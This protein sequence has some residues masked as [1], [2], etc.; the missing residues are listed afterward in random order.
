VPVPFDPSDWAP[1]PV[2]RP[3]IGV[4]SPLVSGS[5]FGAILAGINRRAAAHGR[6][7]LAIQTLDAVS[8]YEGAPTYE[9]RLAWDHVDRFITIINAVTEEY[10]QGLLDA[11]KSLVMIS[12]EDVDVD[13]PKVV[14]DNV[15]GVRASV[16]HLVAHGHRRIAFAGSLSQRD[17]R[18]RYEAYQE[19]LREAG[20]E[21]EPELLYPARE[22]TELGG[23][24]AAEMM[25]AAGMPASAVVTATDYNA[26]GLMATLRQAGVRLPEDLAVIGFDDVEASS[27]QDPALSTVTQR[28]DRMGEMA[29]DLVCGPEIGRSRHCAPTSLV[30]R[31]SCGCGPAVA[32]APA[33]V[34]GGERD[35]FPAIV[36]GPIEAGERFRS[37]LTTALGS[38]T[39][40]DGSDA[41]SG[42]V[43]EH[44]GELLRRYQQPVDDDLGP[45]I[46]R[47]LVA[48]YRLDPRQRTVVALAAATQGLRNELAAAGVPS[49]HLDRCQLEATVCLSTV[50][51]EEQARLTTRLGLSLRTEYAVTFDLLRSHE[52]DARSLT[53]LAR[54]QARSGCFGVW[55]PGL[56]ELL[57]TNVYQRRGDA[58]DGARLSEVLPSLGPETA[59]QREEHYAEAA[60][61]PGEVLDS[62]QAD[63]DTVTYLLPV[64]TPSTNW[65]VLAVVGPVEQAATTGHDLFY[66][67]AGMLGITLD[68]EALVESLREQREGLAD[69]YRRERELVETLRHSEERYA[70]AAR[71]ASDGLWDW[72]LGRNTVYYSPRWKALLGYSDETVGTS[73][74]EWISR[75]H[76][77]DRPGLVEAIDRGLRGEAESFELEH[78][79]LGSDGRHRWTLCRAL[80]VPGGGKPATRLVGSLSDITPRRE[81]EDRLLQRAL[82]DS[83]TGLPN[84][85]LFLDRLER[86]LS[87][88]EVNGQSCALFFMD[89]DNFKTVNDSLGHAAGDELLTTVGKR[90][91]EVL[92]PEDTVARLG[93][94]EFVVLAENVSATVAAEIAERLRHAI[95]QPIVLAE[96]TL[97]VSCS[98]GIALSADHGPDMLLQEADTALYQAKEEGRNRAATYN[99]SMRMKAQRRLDVESILREALE[100]G[101]L[102]V[103][104]QPIVELPS[105]AVVGNE[106][107]VRIRMDD[108]SLLSPDQFIPVAESTGLILPLG[109]AVLNQACA[110]QARW[111]QASN[112]P[113]HV[114][115][116]LSPC[117]L[118]DPSLV[119]Q[120]AEALALSG[121][122]ASQLY[123]ELTETALLD[124]SPEVLQAVNDLKAMGVTLAI[125]DFGTGWAS[126]AYLR[127]FPIDLLKIDRSFVSGILDNDQD[128]EVV[129]AVISLGH[130]L[131][132]K[133]VAEGVETDEQGRRLSEMG[134]DLAQG[135]F[136]GR[137]QL[138]EAPGH[139]PQHS[140]QVPGY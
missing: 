104:Y 26:H 79:I 95:N 46:R 96:R 59:F 41:L 20:I 21:P 69:A 77:D 3:C 14:P 30:L 43:A 101:H 27:H 91:R 68:R 110:Q 87:R 83:L 25:L 100:E 63:D 65:G 55:T 97:A 47:T 9:Q 137:P 99:K 70:L 19:A 105:G 107:L 74:D 29:V 62:V 120:V 8:G 73:P 22:T 84:R 115:V 119:G 52:R 61:P 2:R 57:V 40:D 42:L 11:G 33:L 53:W 114:A 121:L 39:P 92:R 78:R 135:Y 125:D 112:P 75:V 44:A 109:A 38:G 81:L 72:D 71:A 49:D 4:L 106:A 58:P 90:L 132:L 18:E 13:C 56:A 130:A 23:R 37:A 102:V 17:M 6:R 50:G 12:P 1:H 133:V 66:Q 32:A 16:R 108:G 111:A 48:L 126:L 5:Y 51:A 131:A 82:Y 113:G 64:R 94:D 36:P 136:Y 34:D 24:M 67:W 138:V 93:G 118:S 80:A 122:P 28:F 103:A 15:T 128:V 116:N 124:A 140:H 134:C 98:V 54:T 88:S 129:K 31:E 35:G 89:L 127:R 60:F 139:E 76:E 45:A 86:A 123:L 85:S 7:V 10:A 117:Q